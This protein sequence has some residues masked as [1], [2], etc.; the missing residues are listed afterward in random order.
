[1]VR[2]NMQVI[3]HIK[4]KRNRFLSYYFTDFS[5]KERFVLWKNFIVNKLCKKRIKSIQCLSSSDNI[6]T[7]VISL[8]HRIDRRN[9]IE[10]ELFRNN[11]DYSFSDATNGEKLESMDLQYFTKN[12]YNNLSKGSLG[13]A[14]S[15]MK[16]WEK[17]AISKTSDLFLILEDD[18]ILKQNFS[19][20]LNNLLSCIP[21]DFDIIFLGGFNNRP[22]DIEF[23]INESLF[24]SFNPRR[25][26]YS[27]I[28]NSES[29]RKLINLVKPID[30]IYGGIDTFIGKLVRMKK[31]RAYQVF[32]SIVDVDY[33][34]DSN[35][36]NYSERNRKKIENIS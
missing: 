31:L 28:I 29:A 5:I 14:I 25:G 34:F 33:S 23:F 35:I 4:Y 3:D 30:L 8:N 7:I 13:C 36:Y 17:V 11:V 2:V 19:L 26:F 24:K 15:H 6:N 32:P 18:V 27:Y 16:V 22:Q 21:I 20:E 12:A 9:H 10:I 1:M